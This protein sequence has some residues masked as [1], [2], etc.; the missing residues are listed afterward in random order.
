MM[1]NTDSIRFAVSAYDAVIFLSV[2][3]SRH[4]SVRLPQK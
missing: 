4:P 1:K 3:F 2:S